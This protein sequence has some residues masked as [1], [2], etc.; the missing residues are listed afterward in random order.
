G[1]GDPP[2][3][4]HVWD[5]ADGSQVVL[6]VFHHAAIDEW[7]LDLITQELQAILVGAQLPDATPYSTFVRAEHTMRDDGMASDLARRI[8]AGQEATRDLPP[9][10]P[11]PGVNLS[12]DN[13]AMSEAQL[14]ARAASMGVGQ[15]A[16][17]AA[18]LSLALQ[19]RFGQPARWIMTPFARRG[20]EDLQHVIG[21][22]LDMR[23]LE[24]QGD[25]LESVA[26][27]VHEQMLEAQ[28]D[29]ILP[30][31]LLIDSVRQ[32]NPQRAGD[33]TRFGM[34]YRH[35]DD[36]PHAL[37]SSTAT[38]LDIDQ[39]AARFGLCLHVERRSKGIRI[40]LEA[41]HSHFSPDDLRSIG[42]HIVH[43]VQGRSLRA[44]SPEPAHTTT[45]EAVR[46]TASAQELHELTELWQELLGTRPHANSD[47]FMD[48]G[49]SL[50]AMR[51]AAAV[52][53][54]L[55]R[56]LMLN[57]FLRKPT[58]EGLAQS[59]R[60]DTE[61]PY[62]EFSGSA[63]PSSDA[64]WCIAIPGSA[65]RAIDYH[66]LWHKLGE[67]ARD[68]LAFDLATIA[69][70]EAATFDPQRFFARFTALTHAHAMASD[71][72]GPITIMGYSLG[73]L[74]ALDMAAKL[75]DLGHTVERII[76]LD[77]YAPAYLTRT[78]AW[79][80]G[81]LNARVRSLGRRGTAP[82]PAKIEHNSGD[83]HAAEASRATW[84]SIH[85]TLS[86]WP[87][88]K[89]GAPVT[90]VRSAPAWKHVRPVW[91]ARTNGLGPL[92]GADVDVRVIDIEHLAMLTTGAAAVADTIR[93]LVTRSTPTHAAHASP[94]SPIARHPD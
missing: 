44:S 25:T 59:I 75:S 88:P 5:V 35:I 90:L 33:A 14:D 39:S 80:L 36:A 69:T 84:R 17:F 61:H 15:A 53:K 70:G 52:H 71:R 68:M 16:L 23:L 74:V 54:R 72:G 83:A 40:W 18:A 76:L 63:E 28:G 77:A 45:A 47:F 4:M 55:G 57:Q 91:H 11:Q 86:T 12:L 8:A 67:N 2:A 29:R 20:S 89:S 64:P 30:L 49:S 42:E 34:T 73:G 87:I 92:L 79:Y 3:R 6:M 19:E 24:A 32:A 46:D 93:D 37:G 7:S 81:K 1:P 48:G 10:G 9:A 38:L 60:D 65:G 31:E 21:C 26:S 78:P 13:H 27:H 51:L 50:M 62:A 22:C 56:R 82:R 43:L 58:F 94:P 66:R 85:A 41:S